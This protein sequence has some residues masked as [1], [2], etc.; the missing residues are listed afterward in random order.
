MAIPLSSNSS[1]EIAFPVCIISPVVDSS[2]K[3]NYDKE[4]GHAFV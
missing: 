3:V 2:F 1:I 4:K